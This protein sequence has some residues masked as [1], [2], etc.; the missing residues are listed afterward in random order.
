MEEANQAISLVKTEKREDYTR[1]EHYSEILSY[2]TYGVTSSDCSRDADF[3]KKESRSF[4]VISGVLYKG[5]RHPKRVVIDCQERPGIILHFHVDSVSGLHFSFEDT[6]KRVQEQFYWNN[7]VN[8]VK[9]FV[10]Q[11]CRECQASTSGSV[12]CE[13]TKCWNQLEL[14]LH[15]PFESHYVLTIIDITSKWILA[16]TIHKSEELVREMAMFAFSS[17]CQYG[18]PANLTHI[19]QNEKLHLS[20]L[21]SFAHLHEHLKQSD[22]SAL[23]SVPTT[24]D[25]ISRSASARDLCNSVIESLQFF[26]HSNTSSSL[27]WSQ[28]IDIWLFNERIQQGSFKTMFN[29][30]PYSVS[31][32]YPKSKK[33]RRALKSCTLTCRHCGEVFTSRVSFNLHQRRHLVE[34]RETGKMTGEAD[35]GDPR[36][37]GSDEE[38]VEEE[39]MEPCREE[40]LVDN[41]EKLATATQSAISAVQTLMNETKDERGK[42]GKY[43]KYSPELKEEIAEYAQKYGSL[44]AAE[45]YSS[46]LGT[47]VSESTIR[48]FVQTRLRIS[49]A[50]SKEEIGQYAYQFGVEASLKMYAAKI[51]TLNRPM[52]KKFKDLFL[53]NH[54][55]WPL[56]RDDELENEPSDEGTEVNQKYVF[57]PSLRNEIG[58][59]AFHCGNANAVLHFSKKLRFPLKETTVKI[60]K[61]AFMEKH[62]VEVIDAS[63]HHRGENEDE[64]VPLPLTVAHQPAVAP[65]VRLKRRTVSKATKTSASAVEKRRS[66]RGQYSCYTPELRAQIANY[67]TKHGNQETVQYFKETLDIEVPEST[68]R[69]LRDKY[70]RRDKRKMGNNNQMDLGPR[71]RPKRLGKYDVI[72]QNCIREIIAG[73]EKPT[74]FLAIVTAKQV[75]SENEASLLSENGGHIEL[76]TTWAKSFLRR[77]NLGS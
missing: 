6:V 77:M 11:R 73:G 50:A 17:L 22:H 34:A 57:E 32:N 5:S 20:F 31:T 49:N 43:F 40:H 10:R 16:K 13:T 51:P 55:D 68:V 71:G 53:L 26:V 65:K 42:R 56:D 19:S 67:A 15:G 25:F 2:L 8:D 27:H 33:Q 21:Q 58:R 7:L 9:D 39:D 24:L 14:M 76:N 12:N 48:N 3:I 66:K 75:L 52:V 37:D 18:F 60:F 70:L 41:P 35:Q 54:P 72:V 69:G 64:V 44:E 47:P 4:C 36:L 46:K 63:L 29:R 74:A 62:D 23:N 1:S 61:K 59:Y 45:H 30:S 38:E 28:L